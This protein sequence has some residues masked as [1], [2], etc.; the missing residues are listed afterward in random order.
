MLQIRKSLQ[1]VFVRNHWQGWGK[2]SSD[3]CPPTQASA[4]EELMCEPSYPGGIDPANMSW[5][6]V[7]CTPAGTVLCISLPNLGLMGDI[8]ILERLS[9]LND[10]ML[11]D[12]SGN[13]L[14][15]V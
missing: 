14:A 15:G 10:T 7:V 3:M 6:G 13:E 8:S 12:L 2:D 1:D 4:T 5:P 11:I 9:P